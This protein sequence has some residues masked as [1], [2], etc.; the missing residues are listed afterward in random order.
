MQRELAQQ[1]QAHREAATKLEV[2]EAHEQLLSR[3]DS[4]D[5]L[6]V[7]QQT[8]ASNLDVRRWK[9][10]GAAPSMPAPLQAT[11]PRAFPTPWIVAAVLAVVG[12]GAVRLVNLPQLDDVRWL[13]ALGVLVGI[14]W[15]LWLQPS[16]F[17]WLLVGVSLL[18]LALH[19]PPARSIA[20]S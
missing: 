5:Q 13:N 3:T 4:A 7:W 6:S 9:F 15:W 12:W 1:Q 11:R 19:R 8:Q 20:S 2:M 14:A 17:G 16:V 10:S 18:L